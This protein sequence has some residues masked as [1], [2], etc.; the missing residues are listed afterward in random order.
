MKLLLGLLMAILIQNSAQAQMISPKFAVVGNQN[1][2]Q[3]GTFQYN[4]GAEPP[5]LNPITSTD[6]YALLFHEYTHDFLLSRNWDTYAWDPGLAESWEVSKDGKVLTFKIRQG[7]K[8]HDGKPVT[9]E[10]VKFSFDAIFD[11][12]YNAAPKRAYFE[13]IEKA[14]L[15]DPMTIRFTAKTKYFGNLDA[16]AGTLIISP[17][18]IYGDAKKGVKLNKTDVGSGPYKLEKYEQ[19]Q[20]LTIVRNKE[21]WGN[22]IP[23]LKGKYNFERIVIR[24]VQADAIAFEMVKKGQ[25]DL[26]PL[27]AE[28]FLKKAVGPEWGK[29][30]HKVKFENK[31]VKPY[32]FIGWNFKNPMFAER[33]VRVALLHLLNRQLMNEKFNY[34]MSLLATGPW[35]LQSEYA[36]PSVKPVLFDP[37][38]AAA[39]LAKAGWKDE[40]KNGVLEKTIAGKKTEFRFSLLNPNKDYEKYFTV[41]K[42]DLKKAGIDMEIKT[43]EWNAFLKQLD[44][45]KF[46][47]VAL[48]WSG[49]DIDL[50]PK[51]IWHSSS[52][53]KGGSNFISYSNSEVDKLIDQSREELDKAKRV[54]LLRQV[55]AKIAAD[56]PYA[57]MFVPRYGFYA[58]TNKIGKAKDTLGYDVGRFY[59]WVQKP[60]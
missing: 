58:H 2:P 40:D 55:Y 41:Y 19:G 34:G 20:R 51:Q 56:A 23:E 53:T 27:N 35:Y 21:W 14:E 9:A 31:K 11:D 42:E 18:H 1:A 52:S 17:K 13:S 47:A 48:A 33:D 22:N 24:F 57:W 59:W 6:A 60:E 10:D 26:Q 28:Y 8:W 32:G 43:L 36:D 16:L 46:E 54:K 5:T 38:A 49:G 44:D 15:L 7:A 29:T 30:V 50:D 45:K 3:G 12:T 39:L 4:F 25:L 37:K